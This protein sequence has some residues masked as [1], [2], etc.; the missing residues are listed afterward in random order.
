MEFRSLKRVGSRCSYL[1][2]AAPP[3][4]TGQLLRLEHVFQQR[5]PAPFSQ[6]LENQDLSD[7]SELEVYWA[8]L[9]IR[10]YKITGRML[11]ICGIYR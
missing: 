3:A 6:R 2:V 5:K 10:S 11:L 7:K 9:S 8:I 4:F 1:Y